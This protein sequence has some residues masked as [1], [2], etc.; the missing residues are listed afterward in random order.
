[1]ESEHCDR[2]QKAGVK[3]KGLAVLASATHATK[4]ITADHNQKSF[5]Y[6]LEKLMR[7]RSSAAIISQGRK[8][9][10]SNAAFFALF[11]K[12]YGVPAGVIVA[13]LGTETSFG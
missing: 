5:K 12:E 6:T 9:K 13:I 7:V 4:T 2:S 11:E 3:K 1:M 8:K 10:A